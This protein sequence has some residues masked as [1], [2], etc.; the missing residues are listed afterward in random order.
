MTAP[1]LISPTVVE[2]E[3]RR[4]P[5]TVAPR[6]ATPVHT[7][8]NP[9]ASRETVRSGFIRAWRG[10]RTPAP[11]Q[12][13]PGI[14]SATCSGVSGSAAAGMLAASSGVNGSTL[15]ESN[16]VMPTPFGQ[17]SWRSHQIPMLALPSATYGAGYVPRACR[18]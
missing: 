9:L 10:M 8:C 3:T 5:R 17:L 15:I 6:A 14:S 4:S 18:R 11:D 16:G 1:G 13:R 7:D 12:D 2:S